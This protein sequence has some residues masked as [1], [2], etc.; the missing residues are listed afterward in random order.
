MNH[1][2]FNI[3]D[4][5][6]K[7]FIE[8]YK[9]DRGLIFEDK[10]INFN[11][12]DIDDSLIYCPSKQRKEVNEQVLPKLCKKTE[13]SLDNNKEKQFNNN[14]NNQN[15]NKFLPQKEDNKLNENINIKNEIGMDIDI[16]N[17]NANFS[18]RSNKKNEFESEEMNKYNENKKRSNKKKE[19]TD[20]I[21]E[22]PICN[23]KFHSLLKLSDIEEHVNECINGRG[24]EN[25]KTFKLVLEEQL[26]EEGVINL[27][28][29]YCY[30]KFMNYKQVNEHMK[31]CS[32]KT[33]SINSN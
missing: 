29:K 7:D 1:P 11:L 33:D 17:N 10:N 20:R 22:C 3:D 19:N 2:Y 16:E 31:K 13:E 18:F 9:K 24:E 5:Y 23:W 15:K 26:T 14:L 12:K 21:S 32:E 4:D 6:E 30:K 8:I 25:K 27:C 28:C